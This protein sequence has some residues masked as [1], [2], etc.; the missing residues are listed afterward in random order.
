MIGL[1]EADAHEDE[2]LGTLLI[3]A[4]AAICDDLDGAVTQLLDPDRLDRKVA[5]AAQAAVEAAAAETSRTGKEVQVL[6]S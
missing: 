2:A 4:F 1:A 3:G 6:G 5:R